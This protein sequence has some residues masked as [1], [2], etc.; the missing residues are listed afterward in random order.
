MHNQSESFTVS[1]AGLA[2]GGEPVVKVSNKIL[3]DHI[4]RS[5]T[6]ARTFSRWE[7]LAQ[8]TGW[9]SRARPRA[10]RAAQSRRSARRQ[11]LSQLVLAPW[12][13]SN[14][15]GTCVDR[16]CG[17]VF[18]SVTSSAAG[19]NSSSHCPVYSYIR[20]FTLRSVQTTPPSQIQGVPKKGTF[21]MIPEPR[22][23]RSISNNRHPSQSELDKPL[24][25]RKILVS[26]LTRIKRFQSMSMGKFGQAAPNFGLDYS[27]LA[28]FWKSILGHHVLSLVSRSELDLFFSP[29]FTLTAMR[30]AMARWKRCTCSKTNVLRR[31]FKQILKLGNLCSG[32]SGL[33]PGLRAAAVHQLKCDSQGNLF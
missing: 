24:S 4:W 8:R 22:C 7:T 23:K 13:L 5:R 11:V 6:H 21:R 16:L 29:G 28:A 2:G 9:Q 32:K 31:K 1:E 12:N 18:C 25:G 27:A 17:E 19:S 20:P 3:W 33:L 10:P 15:P 30:L 14:W 26:F